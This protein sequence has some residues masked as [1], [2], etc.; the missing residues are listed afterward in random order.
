MFFTNY[1][2]YASD[3]VE[4]QMYN[5]IFDWEEEIPLESI[6][7]LEKI[8]K[9]KNRSLL[10]DLYVKSNPIFKDIYYLFP[11]VKKIKRRLVIFDPEN[12]YYNSY[13]PTTEQLLETIKKEATG[14][15]VFM[16]NSL[17]IYDFNLFKDTSIKGIIFP[18]GFTVLGN[19]VLAYNKL[20]YV[21]L[22]STLTK[23]NGNVFE[24][25]QIINTI[26]FTNFPNSNILWNKNL[27]CNLLNGL[28]DSDVIR[29]T[30]NGYVF[31]NHLRFDQIILLDRD[32]RIEILNKE[33]EWEYEALN[34]NCNVTI[35][36]IQKLVQEKM[37]TKN[38]KEKLI[39]SK[40]I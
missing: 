22:P 35:E 20:A 31:K 6:Y 13:G 38:A 10:Y 27:L 29:E 1:K 30:N 5:S 32:K 26:A 23:I 18:E 36:K 7:R 3:Y 25:G 28:I 37:E 40:R 15:I 24:Y 19:K 21:S 4:L 39:L 8:N 33:L 11:G 17:K 34:D 16:P 2:I 9:I 12:G 14:K